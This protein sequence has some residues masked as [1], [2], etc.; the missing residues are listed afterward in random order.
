MTQPRRQHVTRSLRVAV[1]ATVLV[2]LVSLLAVVILDVAVAHRL[3]AQVDNRLSQRLAQAR[4]EPSSLG[5]TSSEPTATLAPP[6]VTDPDD[7]PVFTWRVRSAGHLEAATPGAPALPV[8]GALKA[9]IATVP[10][11]MGSYQVDVAAVKGGY[12]VAGVSLADVHHIENLIFL[13][14][15]VLGPIGLLGMFLGAFVIGIKASG[16]VEQARIRQLEFTADASHELRTPLSVIDAEVDLALRTERNAS[17]YRQSLERV[18]HESGRLRR[19]VEDLLWLAR[20]DS[21]P[22]HRTQDRVDLATVVESCIGRFAPV[23]ASNELEVRTN[24]CSDGSCWLYASA[25]EMDRLVGVLLDN[26]CRYTPKGG[27]VQLNVVQSAGRVHLVVEDSGPGIAAD[28][29]P[30]LFDRFHRATKEPGGTGLGLAIA[31]SVVRATGG[32][33]QVGDSP[34]GGARMEVAWHQPG[35]G[36]VRAPVLHDPVRNPS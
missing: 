17:S 6:Q 31:D 36:R 14:E 12:L 16:P 10:T 7:A 15:A 26:A 34:L 9:G 30:L 28:Q 27:V 32:R 4:Q 2:G 23:I 5:T 19:I 29:R 25:D 13:A 35:R 18:K 21:S 20:V 3:T 8:R 24:L 11:A 1:T 33:W 22:P